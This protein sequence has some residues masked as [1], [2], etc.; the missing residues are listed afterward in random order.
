[1]VWRSSFRPLVRS[2][3]LS[4]AVLG[5]MP[6]AAT[7]HE[8]PGD[9]VLH[10]DRPK[11]QVAI[12]LDTSNSMDGLI[13]Q[14][15]TQ[16]WTI[17]NE[18]AKSK[19]DGMRPRLE[20]ALYEYGN[21]RL[22]PGEGHIRQ[23]C[24]FT[25][26]LDRLSEKLWE[27]T[28]NGGSEFCGQVISQ[29][30]D[31]LA[32]DN[33]PRTYK[34]IFI[35]GNEPFTQGE[36]DYRKSCA[37]AIGHGIVVNTIHCGTRDDGVNGQ[38]ADGA[39]RGEGEFMWID[40][41]HKRIA[42][43]CPQD[44]EITRLSSDLNST[45][46]AY[47]REGIA[48]ATRQEAQDKIAADNASAGTE[49]ARAAAK[50]SSAYNNAGWDLVDA[51]KEGKVKLDEVKD[52]DLPEAMKKMTPDERRAHVDQQLARRADLSKRIQELNAERAKYVAEQEKLQATEA[53]ETFDS[54]AA[55]IVR[56]QMKAKGFEV[57]K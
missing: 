37:A 51:V 4:S 50:A 47:G 46:V 45:Y 22:S 5:V 15:R 56:E 17:V 34:A 16:L 27:L 7:A 2:L 18:F 21:D 20:V 54:A 48:G 53:G 25:E 42:I 26:D 38:W 35:A 32:W 8:P 39:K 52:E 11:V 57:E 33:N 3:I 14:A 36:T 31:G 29:S 9:V 44:D 12:L 55:K 19:R 1:M 28:T 30:V 13:F 10:R 6:L 41:E 24:A 49:I 40:Q 23:V 43:R